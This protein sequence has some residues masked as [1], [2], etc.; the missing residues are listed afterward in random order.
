MCKL[1]SEQIA[2]AKDMFDDNYS[3]YEICRRLEDLDGTIINPESLRYYITRKD[4]PKLTEREKLAE[5]GT[6]KVLMLG[7]VHIPYQIDGVID[8][9]KK[10]S[11]EISTIIF[12]GDLVDNEEISVFKGLGKGELIDEMVE[13]HQFLKEVQDILPNARKI[14]IKGNH[15][16][17]FDK[18]LAETDTALNS[19][20]TSNILQEIVDGFKKAD[21][22]KGTTTFYERLDYEVVDDWWIKYNDSVVC[23]PSKFSRIQGRVVNDAIDYFVRIGESFT[24]CMVFHTHKV[25][26]VQNFDKFG[27]EVGCTCKPMDYASKSGKLN[28]TNQCNGYHV[29]VYKDGKYDINESKQ[30]II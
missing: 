25:S 24:N 6:E 5:I 30:Y 22:K 4:K 11:N 29:A 2:L 17:R 13:C 19:L 8:I 12:G 9:I 27:F 7:D 26:M 14:L 3:Y 23:H 21:H 1:T 20:H 16:A 15:E 10:H 18:Y 28:L